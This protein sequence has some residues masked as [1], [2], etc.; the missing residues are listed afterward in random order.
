MNA[1][2]KSKRTQVYFAMPWALLILLSFLILALPF[3]TLLAS[4]NSSADEE[5]IIQ[6]KWKHQ[7]QFA[8]YYAALHQGFFAEEGLKVRLNERD[9]SINIIDQVIQQEAHYGVAD[10]V[11]ILQAANN[12]P[13]V[14]VAA[15]MQYSAN[16]IMTMEH[17]EITRPQDLISR[18]IS[19]YDNDSDGIDILA[20]LAK[21][22]IRS[23]NLIRKSWDER[24]DA[25][26][27]NDVDAIVVYV[28]NDPHVFK[29]KGYD[30]NLIYPRDYGVSLYG[31]IL[32][33]H[34]QEAEQHPERVAAIRRA[35]IRGW[36]YALDHKEEM[37]DFI[38]EHYNTLGKSKETLMIEALGMEALIS[39]YTTELGQFDEGR[40]DY[41]VDLL[42]TLNLLETNDIGGKH[43]VFSLNTNGVFL[44]ETEKAFLASLDTIKVGVE[45]IGYPP[46]E[47]L[48]EDG[49]YLG[50]AADYLARLEDLL[51]IRFEFVREDTWLD[52]LEHLS[53]KEIDLIA[54][55]AQTPD[56]L[57]YASFSSP[58]VR[59]QMVIVTRN[60]VEYV[61]N[62][63]QL[64]G[65]SIGVVAD[66]A[67]DELLSRYFPELSLKRYP[68]TVDG[69]RALSVGEVAAFVDNLSVV[70]YLIHREGLANLKVSGQTPYVFDLSIGV[71]NDWPL[72]Q[73]AIDKAL[74]SMSSEEHSD[75]Y[76]RWIRFEVVEHVPWK[77]ILPFIIAA[78]FVA[79]ILVYFLF[80]LR[81]KNQLLAQVSVTDKLTD[82][83]NR[84]HLDHIL[85][86]LFKEAKQKRQSLA[87][88]LF[89]LDR[90]KYINDEYG[91]QKGDEI[92]QVFSKIVKDNV[93][94][95][96]VFGRWGGEEFLL[97]CPFT[98][99]EQAIQVAE[100]IRHLLSEQVLIE[101][102]KVTVSAGV[103]SASLVMSVD[104]LITSADK[105]LYMA[106]EKGRN[107]VE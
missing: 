14:L 78:I 104:A 20:L 90:F 50:I 76:H 84:H 106:K 2:L 38:F 107:R 5:I 66:Y 89:D 52:V 67:P 4:T 6:L 58:Y 60:D 54:A 105:K 34:Q 69:L 79:L 48:N 31:D 29:E 64:Q 61:A 62:I 87:I 102:E 94:S 40:I 97:V 1:L 36:H 45:A 92:L 19:F 13:V 82:S 63:R 93:R 15:I 72:L 44:T 11:V 88:V 95:T 55:A 51:G 27:N 22:G 85:V 32:F 41:I 57:Q 47:M 65:Q 39:R 59:S 96:D 99:T 42:E 77:N 83:Y 18:R 16:A 75:I 8:G 28:T 101:S 12:Q 3:K 9:P 80:Q 10:S 7:F 100:K 33:T 103:A 21:Q 46:F 25:L 73:T 43:L 81:S 74:A 17:S 26:I 71:R 53:T 49:Q 91:H 30:V 37:V 68:S 35:V 23:A 98:N 86:E 24:V 70:S 56:R